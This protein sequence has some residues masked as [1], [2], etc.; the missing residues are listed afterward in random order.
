MEVAGG[1]DSLI[2]GEGQILAQVRSNS[3]AFP[4]T[5]RRPNAAAT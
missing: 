4:V 1:L 3:E 5:T 2:K